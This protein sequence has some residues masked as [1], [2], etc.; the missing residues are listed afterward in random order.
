MLQGAVVDLYDRLLCQNGHVIAN[1][2][3][4]LRGI[5]SDSCLSTTVKSEIVTVSAGSRSRQRVSDIDVDC[6]RLFMLLPVSRDGL[7]IDNDVR[8]R[9][10]TLVFDGYAVHLLCEFPDGYHLTSAPGYR[11]RRP[12]Q[13]VERYGGHA[14]VV[15]RLLARLA[16]SSAVSTEFAIRTRAVCRLADA[17]LSDVA[18]RYP[19]VKPSGAVDSHMTTEQ[20]VCAVDR[21]A[22]VTPLRRDDLRR[23][24]RLADDRADTFGPLHRLLY[25]GI[26]DDG[27]AHALWLCADHFRFM[28]ED[29]VPAKSTNMN[30]IDACMY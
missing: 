28:C 24:L 16:A 17:L 29:V 13:F 8:V 2:A 14:S 15:L 5:L 9:T 25:D 7:T 19:A 3:H 12:R 26:S 20:L 18:A 6:P 30:F 27:G 23:C 10:S 1:V 21:S 4:L 11:L 22:A